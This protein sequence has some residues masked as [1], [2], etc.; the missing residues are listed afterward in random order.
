M[1]KFTLAEVPIFNNLTKTEL[2]FVSDFLIEKKYK[3]GDIVFQKD[4]IRDKLIIIINGQVALKTDI[5]GEQI[6]ALFKDNDF[7]GEMSLLQKGSQHQHSLEV[8]SPELTTV[9]VSAYNWATVVKKNPDLANKIYQN[10]AIA[11]HNRLKHANNKLVT[12]FATGKIIGT[13]E[14]LNEIADS[15]LKIVLEI[16]PSRKA[17]F[18]TFSS[19]ASQIIWRKS[20]GFPN[21]KNNSNYDLAKDPLLTKLIKDPQTITIDKNDWSKE[22]KKLPYKS[23][24]LIVTPIHIKNNVLGFLILADKI[25]TH[26]FS[27]NNKILLQAIANQTAPAIEHFG[28]EELASAAAEV[29]NVYIDPFARF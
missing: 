19:V 10:I 1:D 21:I 27:L 22:Y 18:A 15:I 24:S 5:Y 14:N 7:L 8:V 20:I 11:V 9:E 2:S 26:N 28:L 12:L 4:G 25:N 29:K 23:T 17:L 3:Q 13:H 16:I 6:I